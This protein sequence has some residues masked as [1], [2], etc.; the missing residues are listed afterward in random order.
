M[1]T[2]LTQAHEIAFYVSGIVKRTSTPVIVKVRR[3]QNGWSQRIVSDEHNERIRHAPLN[4][5]YVSGETRKELNDEW[6]PCDFK[7]KSFRMCETLEEAREH[8]AQYS[9]SSHSA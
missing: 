3:N 2:N 4:V 6:F 9:T 8:H 5:D 1:T 7:M